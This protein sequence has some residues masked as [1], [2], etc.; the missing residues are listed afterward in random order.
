MSKRNKQKRNVPSTQHMVSYQPNNQVLD[1]IIPVYGEFD[2]LDTCVSKIPEAVGDLKYR[3]MVID[4]GSPD[5]ERAKTFFETHPGILRTTLQSNVG[6]PRACNILMSKCNSELVLLVTPDVWYQ[7]DAIKVLYDKMKA[8]P[9]IGIMGP[10]LLFPEGSPWG[11]AGKIQHAGIEMSIEGN[12]V[13][14]FIGWS[15]DH[16]KA[17]IPCEVFALTGATL[18]IR[19]SAWL[20]VGGYFEGYGTGTFEDVEMCLTVHELGYKIMYEPTAVATHHVGASKSQY[21]LQGNQQVFMIRCGKMIL[22]TEWR[23]L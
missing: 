11:P 10:K 4:N 13:H 9:Q 15:V 3:I 22:W 23:R 14:E 2:F 20:K 21:N 17:N 18:M 1:I 16:P 6:Y 8:D 7:K 12:P 19:R 5:K